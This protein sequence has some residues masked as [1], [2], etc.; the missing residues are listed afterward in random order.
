M[1]Q[2]ERGLD[3]ALAQEQDTKFAEEQKELRQA[4]KKL[5][6]QNKSQTLK[7]NKQKK[8]YK[9][10]KS[11]ALKATKKLEEVNFSN[12]KLIYTNRILKS[13]SLNERQKEKLVEAISKVGSVEEAKIVFDTLNEN[14]SPKSNNAPKTLN[15]AVS[16]NNP[17]ILKSN[18]EKQPAGQNQVDRLKKIGR[19]YLRR[20]KIMS[21]IEKLT[22][23]VINR[24]LSREV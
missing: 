7:V 4:L 15:E 2:N 17:L 19:N 24:D 13:D 12:A 14:L 5:Q 9:Q 21:I 20:K 10:L 11:I 3:I 23:G 18:T 16:K 6:E 8:E 22:E 1:G